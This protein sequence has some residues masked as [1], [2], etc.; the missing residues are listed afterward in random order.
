MSLSR[1]PTTSACRTSPLAR[2]RTRS[3][4][5][6]DRF[7]AAILH[8]AADELSR[9]KKARGPGR[10]GA[11]P[12]AVGPCRPAIT[13]EAGGVRQL[14]WAHVQHD[15]RVAWPG[16]Q[17]AYGIRDEL[18]VD[19]EKS[20]HLEHYIVHPAAARVDGQLVY[21][22]EHLA[23]VVDYLRIKIPAGGE[24]RLGER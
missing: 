21:L 16:R 6:A 23:I 9:A 10:V 3:C 14:L 20:A 5:R 22:A 19:A 11:L 7:A 13:R 18:F 12:Y 1:E 17:R 8:R 15:A 24:R 2:F 4:S